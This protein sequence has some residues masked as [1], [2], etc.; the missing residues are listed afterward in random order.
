MWNSLEIL[1]V[2]LWLP[3]VTFCSG[4][5]KWYTVDSFFMPLPF[6]E[7]SPHP[8]PPTNRRIVE[9]AYRSI[10]VRPFARPSVCLPVRLRPRPRALNSNGAFKLL[11]FFFF[12]CVS[13]FRRGHPCLLEIFLVV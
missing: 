9:R 11:F 10:P 12:L 7:R 4:E 2:L 8:P 5:G 13:N 3:L 1:T 6:E